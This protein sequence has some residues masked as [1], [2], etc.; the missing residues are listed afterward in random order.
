MLL[1]QEQIEKRLERF[2]G[3]IRYVIPNNSMRIED[4][5]LAQQLAISHTKPLDIYIP[6]D[7]VEKV[8]EMKE[9]ISHF[10]LQ[11]NVY[12]GDLT[13]ARTPFRYFNMCYASA[14]VQKQLHS[15]MTDQMMRESLEIL[16]NIFR[17]KPHNLLLFEDVIFGLLTRV[18]NCKWR[19]CKSDEEKE[20]KL[21]FL[22]GE[23]VAKH[24]E[25]KVLRAMKPGVLYRPVNPYFE[26]CDMLWL[27]ETKEICGIQVTFAET[28]AKREGTYE[29]LFDVLG[30]DKKNGQIE[31][32][33]YS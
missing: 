14:Y 24:E 31:S 33:L 30:L 27:D 3:V 11:Y 17:G 29:K 25:T 1:T 19:I 28:H 5:Q 6:G 10:V 13:D 20:F 16:R 22:A 4:V 12:K 8:D 23:E 26:A 32:V 15:V 18:K 7:I 9:N 2:G 21:N